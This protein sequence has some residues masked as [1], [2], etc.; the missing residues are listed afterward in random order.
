MS[1]VL[2]AKAIGKSFGGLAA[3]QGVSLEARSGQILSVIG[4]NGAGKTTLFNCLS[5]IYRPDTGTV[6][7]DGKDVTG[8]A[9]HKIAQAGLSRSFQ[10]IRLF[11]EMTS[12]QNVLVGR[13]SRTPFR[14]MGALLRTKAW[15]ADE[16]AA[17]EKSLELLELVGLAERRDDWARA[18]PY[19]LQRRLEVARA[20]ATEPKVLL[21]DEPGAGMNPSEIAS[22]MD[23]VA[24][25]RSLG[26]AV[27]VIEHHMK[28]VME[29]SDRIL[30]LDHGEPIAEG[31][32]REVRDDPR[33]IEAYLGRT[34]ATVGH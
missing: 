24:K 33:V 14:P 4:P 3:V 12:L 29:I 26:V 5:G 13:F 8:L 10:N 32:P 11:P 7:L 34:E 16:R 18:L 20:L 31:T 6:L 21:L 23:L 9:S 22:M 30:V 1:A 17:K 27:V 28:L 2:Q 25:I 15:H 19:G